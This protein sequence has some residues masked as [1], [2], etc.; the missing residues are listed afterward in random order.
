MGG[1]KI[2]IFDFAANG[3]GIGLESVRKVIRDSWPDFGGPGTGGWVAVD[4]FVAVHRRRE[5]EMARFSRVSKSHEKSRLGSENRCRGPNGGK[6]KKFSES[7]DS[8]LY[9][10]GLYGLVAIL[11]AEN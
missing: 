1:R 8:Q 7:R 10:G 6:T 2:E 9:F 5:G 3:R 4:R 11:V